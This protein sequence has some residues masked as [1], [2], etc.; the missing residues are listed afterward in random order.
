VARMRRRVGTLLSALLSPQPWSPGCRGPD[1]GVPRRRSPSPRLASGEVRDRHGLSQPTPDTDNAGSTGDSRP[2]GRGNAAMNWQN[3][4]DR[5]AGVPHRTTQPWPECYPPASRLATFATRP[6]SLRS[7]ATRER[8]P[9]GVQDRKGRIA[10]TWQYHY[11]EGVTPPLQSPPN[12]G[13][14]SAI[15]LPLRYPP[16]GMHNPSARRSRGA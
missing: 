4:P 16:S 1:E 15:R 10:Q 3:I 9:A 6:G 14:G 7:E 13:Y 12:D 11:S 5:P 8:W 2:L